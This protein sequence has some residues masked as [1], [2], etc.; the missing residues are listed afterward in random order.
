M[1]RDQT[2]QLPLAKRSISS[3]LVLSF[4]FSLCLSSSVANAKD[5]GPIQNIGQDFKRSLAQK[6][7]I[8]PIKNP[9]PDAN[10]T[11]LAPSNTDILKSSDLTIDQ[12]TQKSQE[13]AGTMFIGSDKILV[14]P[15]VLSGLIRFNNNL[16]PYGLDSLSS[17]EIGLKEALQ[18]SLASNLNIKLNQSIK[19]KHKWSFYGSLGEFLP[20]LTN[21]LSVQ[22]L[23]GAFASPAGLAISIDNPYIVSTS[24]FNYYLYKGGGILHGA[25]R[26]KHDFKAAKYG[27]TGGINDVLLDTSKLYYQLALNDAL[28]QIRMKAVE[29]SE[30]IVRLNQDLFENGV[31]TKLDLLQARTQ[32]SR[33][34]QALIS[35]QVS[36]RQAAIALSTILNQSADSDLL[37]KERV[38]SKVRIIDESLNIADLL[39]IAV[40]NRP[41]LKQYEELRLAAKETIKVAKS[42]LLP[43]IGLSGNVTSTGS[44]DQSISSTN[45]QNVPLPSTDSVVAPIGGG[46]AGLPLA[47]PSSGTTRGPKHWTGRALFAIG[48]NVN[49]T[50]GGMGT[51]EAAK[52]KEATVE[53]RRRQIEFN[54]EM[55]R[56]YKEV[57]DSYLNSMSAE[58]L[59]EETSDQVASSEEQ[60]TIAQ[61]RLQEGIGTDTDVVIAE[62]DYIEALTNKAQAIIQFNLAQ[63]QL[64]RDIGRISVDTITSSQPLKQ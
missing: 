60:L 20:S 36:R 28:L 25:L 8:D 63:I 47:S 24:A 64:L 56:V 9:E 41:E 54:T 31:A 2:R 50:L 18:E 32:R 14:K 22:K 23:G 58:S 35:Q 16:N 3:A 39:R 29:K 61:L 53:A 44:R 6:P 51:V 19:D 38:V 33:D 55:N 46:G 15:I 11:K 27:L 40:D 13:T 30:A 34:R 43:T 4:L 42:K 5:S 1:H 21:S 26:H 57:R 12:I 7:T 49:W 62:R 17:K 45:S 37:L 48:V 59:I 52:V 10:N